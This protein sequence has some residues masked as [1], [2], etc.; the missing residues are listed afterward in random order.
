MCRSRPFQPV[1]IHLPCKTGH[2]GED[3]A[4]LVGL[5]GHYADESYSH[6][7]YHDVQDPLCPLRQ[8]Q[9]PTWNVPAQILVINEAGLVRG[10]P[11]TVNIVALADAAVEAP[12]GDFNRHIVSLSSPAAAIMTIVSTASGLTG[13]IGVADL[14]TEVSGGERMAPLG[15][16]VSST[17]IMRAAC[18]TPALQVKFSPFAVGLLDARF[19]YS[20]KPVP[21][22]WRTLSTARLVQ[23]TITMIALYED[24]MESG[25]RGHRGRRLTKQLNDRT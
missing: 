5:D 2:T 8:L 11:F 18:G 16:I 12:V 3:G 4:D 20:G 17:S 1:W 25:F 9:I 22:A 14:T 21:L 13:S 6:E 23:D 10:P 7:L 24:F 19:T 15:S